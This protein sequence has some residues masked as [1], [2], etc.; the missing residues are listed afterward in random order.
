MS[1]IGVDRPKRARST[2]GRARS[3]NPKQ[4]TASKRVSILSLT[5]DFDHAGPPP[6]DGLCACGGKLHTNLRGG[7]HRPSRLDG[8]WQCKSCHYGLCDCGSKA[9]GPQGKCHSCRYGLCDCGGKAN[10]PDGKCKQCH[11]GLCDCG[12]KA[13]GPDGKCKQC[14]YGLCDCGSKATGPDG[15]C[16]SCRYGICTVPDCG[17]KAHGPDGWCTTHFYK[18]V[19][20][21][22]RETVKDGPGWT[23]AFEVWSHDTYL[24]AVHGGAHESTIGDRQSHYRRELA[25]FGCRLERWTAFYRPDAVLAKAQDR[26]IVRDLNVPSIAAVHGVDV[27]GLKTESYADIPLDAIICAWDDLVLVTDF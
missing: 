8:L 21:V 12:S 26:D 6:A 17:N 22:S 1:G 27:D 24:G 7:E 15:K 14:H 2:N 5:P 10:G 11:Y 16:H 3:K 13:T 25:K 23:Y 20:Y 18:G 9:S 4:T 19:D